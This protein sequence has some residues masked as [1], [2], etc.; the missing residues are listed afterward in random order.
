MSRRAKFIISIIIAMAVLDTSVF[1]WVSSSA[2]IPML[3]CF[4]GLIVFLG[5]IIEKDAEEEEAKRHPKDLI[6]EEKR[7]KR[8]A[9]L[10]WIILMCGI[11]GEIITSFS[12]AAWDVVQNVNTAKAIANNDPLNRPVDDVEINASFIL[13]TNG[14]VGS[15]M[16]FDFGT[17]VEL[18]ES[19]YAETNTPRSVSLGSFSV[20][21]S[22][23]TTPSGL[24]DNTG[25]HE[26][27]T[28]QFKA[29]NL[30]D[31]IQNGFVLSNMSPLTPKA[32]T[33]SIQVLK[34]HSH[35]VPRD[36]ELSGDTAQMF[37]NG[38]AT[39]IFKIRPQKTIGDSN[40]NAIFYATNTAQGR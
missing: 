16:G 26:R 15:T 33:R 20:L 39:A 32:I 37:V 14:F 11:G 27:L 4:G 18:L 5:L 9:K 7:I 2:F 38:K 17:F 6:D 31:P 28:V 22:E 40:G 35:L 13:K 8:L 19:S 10:G 25:H 30:F 1:V 24:D 29:N 12:F 36:A 34:F 3:A 23:N 21:Y